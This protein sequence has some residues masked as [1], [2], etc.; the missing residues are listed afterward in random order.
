MEERIQKIETRFDNLD[1]R[2]N[3]LDTKY[4]LSI[5]SGSYIAKALEDMRKLIENGQVNLVSREEFKPVRTIVY[6]MVGIIVTAFLVAIVALV[7]P[8]VNQ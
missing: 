4:Q 6:G 2:I 8:R 5:Q 1:K 3:D 7:I